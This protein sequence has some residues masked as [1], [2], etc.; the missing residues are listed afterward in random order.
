MGVASSLHAHLRQEAMTLFE[1]MRIPAGLDIDPAW[2]EH[3]AGDDSGG[4]GL[5][6]HGAEIMWT[7]HES[8]KLGDLR[9]RTRSLSQLK[10]LVS[11]GE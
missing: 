11:A 7:E 2:L 4:R 9:L 8:L 10:G 6:C 3:A 5:N 1:A